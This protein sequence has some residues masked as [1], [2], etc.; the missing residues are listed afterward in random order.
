L[1]L[2]GANHEQDNPIAEFATVQQDFLD[3]MLH[4]AGLA[5]LMEEPKCALCDSKLDAQGTGLG[6]AASAANT[7]VILMSLA[8]F[9]LKQFTVSYDIACRW[10]SQGDEFDA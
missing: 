8:G 5:D 3:E 1:G 6:E 9:D 4:L 10:R 2:D 7:D